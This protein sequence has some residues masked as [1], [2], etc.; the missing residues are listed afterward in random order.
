MTSTRRQ[1]TRDSASNNRDCR[2]NDSNGCTGIIPQKNIQD[3]VEGIEVCPVYDC[4][5]NDRMLPHC[6]E[7]PELI[8]ERF[9]RYRDPGMS[10]EEAQAVLHKMEAE[11]RQRSVRKSRPPVRPRKTSR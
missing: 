4:C 2:R 6:G 7:C 8:C 1:T 3:S 5:V 10:E 9:T 11:L